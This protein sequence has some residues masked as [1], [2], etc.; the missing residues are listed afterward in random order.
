[1]MLEKIKSQVESK[2]G[3]EL[4]FRFNGSRNQIEEFK[5]V[6]NAV[7][8]AVFTILVDDYGVRSFSYSDLLTNNLEI[9]GNTCL[10]N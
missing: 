2:I 5:G 7:Y 1:M 3:K 4:Y 6:V 10:D 9:I 8:S